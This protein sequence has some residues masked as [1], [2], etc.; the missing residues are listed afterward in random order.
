MACVTG[1]VCG[2]GYRGMCG[3]GGHAC[4]VD[5]MTDMCKNITLQT[6]RTHENERDQENRYS[7]CTVN[8]S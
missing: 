3:K 7:L 8:T 2:G 5:K 6:R 1:V 4:S